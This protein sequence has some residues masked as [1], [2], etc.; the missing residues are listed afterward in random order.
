MESTNKRQC[1]LLKLPT[2]IRYKIY[3]KV[4]RLD[5]DYLLAAGFYGDN[6]YKR[7]GSAMQLGTTRIFIKKPNTTKL[8]IPWVQL[9][10]SC[11]A[12][13]DE[14]KTYID[15]GSFLKQKTSR[16]LVVD[17]LAQQ[18]LHHLETASLRRIPCQPQKYQVIVANLSLLGP[19]RHSLW[20]DYAPNRIVL[21]LWH[22]LNR[23]LHYGPVFTRR[24][25]LAQPL[26][27][28]SLVIYIN[29]GTKSQ[30]GGPFNKKMSNVANVVKMLLT[31]G[32]LSSYIDQIV[33]TD[34]QG[35]ERN[36]EVVPMEN[37]GIP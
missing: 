18:N 12:F 32:V 7:I 20:G 9:R 23:I 37:V 8:S 33:M 36:Y 4:A 2:E 22:M 5:V 10:L 15:S 35:N 6:D 21:E 34:E 17:I 14:L 24:I 3:D 28:K 30:E 16:A 29:T 11:K 25:P 13:R 26:K 31:T 1:T 27:L 19:D